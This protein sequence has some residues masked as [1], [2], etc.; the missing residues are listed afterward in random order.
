VKYK[1]AVVPRVIKAF[2]PQSIPEKVGKAISRLRI[3][4]IE[5]TPKMKK[6]DCR[7]IW[8]RAS[9][10]AATSLVALARLTLSIKFTIVENTP[11]T[12][13]N[14]NGKPKSKGET[15]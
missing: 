13:T 2:T 14:F 10:K 11:T 9:L 5:I 12:K 7:I 8:S 1:D 3:V 15:T 4:A 6:S